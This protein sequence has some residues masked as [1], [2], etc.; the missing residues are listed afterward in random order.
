MDIEIWQIRIVDITMNKRP[1][2]KGQH[3][4]DNIFK[5]FFLTKLIVVKKYLT[6][7]T[8]DKPALV[9]VMAFWRREMSI[10]LIL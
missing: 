8:D 10:W 6:D 5:E 9:R 1:K 2:G 4:A 3:F 7:I